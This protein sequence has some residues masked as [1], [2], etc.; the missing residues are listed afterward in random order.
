MTS[1]SPTSSS[2][3]H[4][5]SGQAKEVERLA[6]AMAEDTGLSWEHMPEKLGSF[7][8][9][10]QSTR[11]FWIDRA[12]A[13]LRALPDA[14]PETIA[15][16]A[17]AFFEEFWRDDPVEWSDKALENEKFMRAIRAAIKA[18]SRAMLGEKPDHE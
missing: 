12:S 2:A 5:G 15:A 4:E 10:P 8:V 7:S 16:A 17:K 1:P 18:L 11:Q 3:Q 14:Q 9:M 6:R 13:L